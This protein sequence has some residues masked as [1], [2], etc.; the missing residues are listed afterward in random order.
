MESNNNIEIGKNNIQGSEQIEQSNIPRDTFDNQEH[1]EQGDK[2]STTLRNI[3]IVGLLSLKFLSAC[4][5][6]RI[7]QVN[8]VSTFSP[9]STE[10]N[11]L[12]ES[13][14]STGIS[15][16]PNQDGFLTVEPTLTQTATKTPTISPTVT[17]TP[18]LTPTEI[19]KEI[20]EWNEKF[21]MESIDLKN[22]ETFE[23]IEDE[24]IPNGEVLT[25]KFPTKAFI[26]SSY[27][28]LIFIND[29]FHH[30]LT[31]IENTTFEIG[32]IKTVRNDKGEEV[33]IGIVSKAI[34]DSSY[35]NTIALIMSAKDSQGEEQKFM[36]VDNATSDTATYIMTETWNTNKAFLGN[37][38]TLLRLAE[39]QESNGPFQK[40]ETYSFLDICKSI[41]E[42][43]ELN[44]D[45]YYKMWTFY[46]GK[47]VPTVLS[48]LSLGETPSL[49]II[50]KRKAIEEIIPNQLLLQ[51]RDW[52]AITGVD[53][54]D[55]PTT[56]Y[57]FKFRPKKNGYFQIQ[58]IVTDFG[59]NVSMPGLGGLKPAKVLYGFTI[60]FV[61]EKPEN[62]SELIQEILDSYQDY[63]NWKTESIHYG[64]LSYQRF[65]IT[66]HNIPQMMEEVFPYA[67]D[68]DF[69]ESM[70]EK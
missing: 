61:E 7:V 27:D 62:K 59:P 15:T 20:I 68:K 18:T 55:N 4:M 46:G 52:R 36:W 31:M 44:Y 34:T 8:P 70:L 53:N 48:L 14:L 40:G 54:L 16:T 6:D 1:N 43:K 65:K 32:Q 33:T 51:E 47:E 13:D 38:Q 56:Q 37:Y 5:G 19:Q 12:P 58:P 26:I 11:K 28:P 17:S 50:E 21:D 10:T 23:V 67:D 63:F 2:K 9:Q 22:W 64:V 66:E 60:S 29:T 45:A 25:T 49:E 30:E 35:N 41:T 69:E 3:A 39:F 42:S 24:I 57:D